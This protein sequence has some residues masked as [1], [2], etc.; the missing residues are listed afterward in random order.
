MVLQGLPER[1]EFGLLVLEDRGAGLQ[2]QR[3]GHGKGGRGKYS[4]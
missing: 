4:Y 3:G 2:L 1:E